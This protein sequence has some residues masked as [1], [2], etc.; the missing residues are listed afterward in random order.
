[1]RSFSFMEFPEV[2]NGSLM[3]QIA[4]EL[5]CKLFVSLDLDPERYFVPQSC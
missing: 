5:D 2:A 4:S 1:M 3:Y